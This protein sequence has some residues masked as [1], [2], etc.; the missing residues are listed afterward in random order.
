MRDVTAFFRTLTGR[1]VLVTAATAVVAVIVTSLVAVPVAVRSVNLQSRA[2]LMAKTTLAEEVL[3]DERPA[4]RGR[5][6]DRLRQ[7]DIDI[8]LIRRG[9]PDRAGLPARVVTA[10]AEGSLVDVRARVNGRPSFVA[11]RP[12]TGRDAGVVL[13][14]RASTGTA[15]RV[16]GSVWVALLAGL[17]GGVIAGALLARFVTRPIERAASAAG[18]LAAGDRTIRIS[19][20]GPAEAARLADAI[21]QLAEALRTSEGRER[22][23]LLSVSHELRTPLATIR[24]YAEALADRVIEADDA[25]EAGSTMLAEA[26]RLD[27]LISDL[28][29]LARLEAADLPLDVAAV[30]LTELVREAGQAW[31]TRCGGRDQAERGS[32][33]PGG[34]PPAPAGVEGSGHV[35]GPRLVVELPDA[36]VVVDT[37]PGRIRQVIDGLCENAIRVLPPGAPLVL[38]VRPRG[39]GGGLVEVRDGGPGLTDD[40]L[41]VAFQRGELNRRYRGV[42]AVGSGLGLSLAARLVGRLGGRI[43]AGHAPEG[44][45]MFTVELGGSLPGSNIGLTSTEP[46]LPRIGS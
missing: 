1:A 5:I 36:P 30:D 6:A 20:R 44:G 16:F 29:V 22:E 2:E 41:A 21:N 12:L 18:R 34:P 27:R 39:D 11:G 28:L 26:D 31:R 35:G 46:W 38:A 37:D 43:T 13:V 17:L 25:A 3:A 24:G 19:R 23:F 40:D 45:A 10:V 15:A 4:A 8:Y 32:P 9:V 7:D 14:Q 33:Q 42:R